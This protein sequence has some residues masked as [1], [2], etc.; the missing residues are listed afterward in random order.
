MLNHYLV[1][2]QTIDDFIARIRQE[3]YGMLRQVNMPAGGVG[4]L[5]HSLPDLQSAAYT[6]EKGSPLD[7][8][9]LAESRLGRS[10]SVTAAGI[11]RGENTL[12]SP[13]A[14]TVF[15]AGDVVYLFATQTALQAAAPLFRTTADH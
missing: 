5:R 4:D 15:R 7:G 6:V 2:R 13:P 8:K 10:Y 9:T 3:N 14:D 1:P 12:T 11:R